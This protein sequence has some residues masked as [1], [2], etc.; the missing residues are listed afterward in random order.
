M[1]KQKWFRTLSLALAAGM[2]LTGCKSAAEPAQGGAETEA[3]EVSEDFNET[4]YPIVNEKIN[5]SMMGSKAAIQ[6]AWEGLVFFKDMEE[7]TNISFTF[8]TPASE[9]FEEKKNLALA[10]GSYPDVFFGANLT[11][12]QQIKYG[13]EE[14]ILIPLDELIIKYGPNITQM[15]E[16]HP[17]VKASITAP[18][19]HIYALPNFNQG[20]LAKTP[21]WW[22]NA[23]WLE[24][25]G[26]TELPTTTEGFYELL[27]RFKTEDPNGNGEADEIPFTFIVNAGNMDY[28][29]PNLYILPAFGVNSARIYVDNG[30]VKYGALEENFKEYL[31]YMNRLFTE[32]LIDQEWAT[33]DDSTRIGKAKGNTVGIAAQAIPQNL[34]DVTDAEEAKAYPLAPALSSEFSGGKQRYL[35]YSQGIT[36]GAFAITN[37]CTAPE[38]MIRWADYLYGE[39]G[40]FFIHYGNEGELW[41]MA[42]D[43]RYEHI[44]PEGGMSVEEYRGGI[45]TPD[46]GT[47]TPKWVRPSTVSNWVDPFQSV[48]IE[49]M[50]EL[51]LPYA[52]VAFPSTYFMPEQQN[53]IDVI[54]AD[55]NKYMEEMEAAFF[56]GTKDIDSE[57][58][59]FTATLKKMNVEELIRIYQE[60]YDNWKAAQ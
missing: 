41:E 25:L 20:S 6:G 8:D 4:G 48:R 22:Y 60:S 27:K 37:K 26:V 50:D 57:Y 40:S 11:T 3:A 56:A 9:V 12:A 14:G 28:T 29:D 46:C 52:D 15:F 13:M 7:K 43:G 32:G 16:E 1:R 18:D 24:A 53:R 23:E 31:K 39:E 10:G 30:V 47:T 49:Q 2:L 38:A 51:V 44:T 21:T 45:V 36:Q 59:N 55:L 19:G 17:E 34:Y 33:Q 5:V 54:E 35:L 58:D 42:E